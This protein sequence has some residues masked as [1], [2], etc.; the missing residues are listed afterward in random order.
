M[1]GSPVTNPLPTSGLGTPVECGCIQG[2]GVKIQEMGKERVQSRSFLQKSSMDYPMATNLNPKRM[3]GRNLILN[4]IL[5]CL[6][7]FVMYCNGT[8]I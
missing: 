5:L 8:F 3:K 6:D 2:M 4:S 7:V 1:A